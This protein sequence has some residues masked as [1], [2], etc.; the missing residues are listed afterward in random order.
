[1]R[2]CRLI[3]GLLSLAV[4]SCS[5]DEVTGPGHLSRDTQT[6]DVVYA[7]IDD[8]PGAVETK[9]YT[10]ET[11]HVFWNADDRVTV[12]KN[13]TGGL[14]YTFQGNDGDA[15]GSFKKTDNDEF[16]G[17]ESLG[18]WNYA[19][20]P[21]MDETRIDHHGVITF[22]LPAIQ[23]YSEGSF[24]RGANTM[25][26][27]TEDDAFR[28]KNVGGYITLSFY[29]KGVSVSSITFK[30]NNGE[31]IAG[32][33]RIDMSG[34][35]PVVTMSDIDATEEI[36]LA[37]SAPVGLGSSGSNPTTFW[38]VIPPTTF[39]KGITFTVNTSE[40]EVFERSSTAP[41]T[42]DRNKKM[43]V[44]AMEIVLPRKNNVIYYTS[45]DGG[46]V[47]PY[48]VDGFG[49]NIISNEVVDGQ[50]VMVFDGDVTSIGDNAF[51]RCYGTTN[52]LT[53]I[54]IPE[55]VTS[56]GTWAF[57][58]CYDLTSI[59]IPRSVESIGGSPFTPCTSLASI[60][61]EE[62]NTRY[63]SRD[64]CNA[65]IETSSNTLIKGCMNTVIPE[66]VTDIGGYAFKA[67]YGLTSIS[68]PE[69]VE[70]IGEGVFSGCKDLSSIVV[71]SDNEVFDS[72]NDCNAVIETSSNT[73]VAG[74]NNTVIPEGVT[75]IGNYAF[76]GSLLAS[77]A[78][79]EGITF[80]GDYAFHDCVELASVSLPESLTSIGNAAFSD[81]NKLVS[82]CLPESVT[83]IGS[84]A[85]LYCSNLSSITVNSTVPPQL[86]GAYAFNGTNDCPIYVPA[87][88]L[89]TY[90][91]AQ[92][93]SVYA[94]R[95]RPLHT[96]TINGYAYVDLGLSVKW[97]VCNL[98]AE[99]PEQFGDYYSWGETDPYD[100]SYDGVGYGMGATDILD[101][102]DDAA[103]IVMGGTWRIPTQEEWTE[104]LENCRFEWCS[105]N[106]VPGYKV[107]SNVSGFESSYIFLPAAGFM[108]NGRFYSASTVF[109]GEYYGDYI[110]ANNDKRE[111]HFTD[112]IK[113]LDRWNLEDGRSIR[114]VSR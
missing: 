109:A 13:V 75:G 37:C 31:K 21:H 25:T 104:L 86:G 33:C 28:F 61:V 32:K 4:I 84:Q 103:S 3:I 24:G 111:F 83:D 68:I 112:T 110:C 8:R 92:Y 59:V 39:S 93:W 76:D 94:D 80:I 56:I 72:R 64:N 58:M 97:A 43:Q 45:T 52:G 55:T 90:K 101:A 95:I 41:F 70:S 79:P 7:T 19:I 53:S 29:G 102:A 1:M 48:N 5:I 36:T 40:G 22:K 44:P 67:C 9:T 78:I 16:A 38:F 30:G 65:L 54:D 62:G 23:A 63:D 74:C 66:T 60:S 89:E 88:A 91:A 71:S 49:A 10:D 99:A 14:E 27:K 77:V 20:Y 81:C 114:A 47:T 105:V 98:G 26:A 107:S 15:G 46:I 35:E 106:D 113:G 85:F 18:G 12:F 6:P 17:G 82:V 57:S 108:S 100:G 87:E 50:G 2:F 11:L 42:L 96:G 73:L 51:Y 69:S 34:G